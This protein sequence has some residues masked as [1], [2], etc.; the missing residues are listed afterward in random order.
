MGF[1]FKNTQTL[2]PRQARYQDEIISKS[3]QHCQLVIPAYKHP[4]QTIMENPDIL[5]TVDV[6]GQ[7]MAV[8][9]TDAG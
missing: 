5:L 1:S 2:G 3:K 6:V 9:A 4:S 8:F 7:H